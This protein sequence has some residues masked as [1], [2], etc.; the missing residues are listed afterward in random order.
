MPMPAN[1]S[2]NGKAY[3]HAVALGFCEF[4]NATII[5]DAASSHA[6]QCYERIT[7]PQQQKFV[8]TAKAA[9]EI[10]M[11]QEPWL[12][13][14]SRVAI[15]IQ[16]DKA[17][18]G[19]DVRDVLLVANDGR[20]VGIS[21]KT[22]HEALKHSRLSGVLDFVKSWQIDAAGCSDS[23]WAAIKP[24]FKELAD[25]RRDSDRKAQW[26]SEPNVYGRFYLPVLDAWRA[27]L[28]RAVKQT[29]KEQQA[30]AGLI[31]YLYGTNDFYKVIGKHGRKAEIS[32]LGI[33]FHGTL[34]TRR[35]LFPQA[36][37]D[38]D[39]NDGGPNTRIA[40][41]D[42]GFSLSFRIHSASK[43]VE[44]S[45]KF[46]INALSLPPTHFFQASKQLS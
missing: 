11:E 20:T 39:C 46:D 35:S 21:C 33:N 34:S 4:V 36:L 8:S 27:E 43:R 25:I 22:N 16:P 7:L 14:A 45:L 31:S 30:C 37:L 18:V 2:T 12:G 9:A 38:V 28:L 29:G 26:D 10:I 15:R 6:K 19:G 23:Y 17:G 5:E 40:R 32:V 13:D 1:Q 3:E 41:F 44:A 42:R 24:I